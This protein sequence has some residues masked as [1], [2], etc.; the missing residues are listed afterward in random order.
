[1]GI[2]VR[3]TLIRLHYRNDTGNICARDYPVISNHE[4][5]GANQVQ[6]NKY[7]F[8]SRQQNANQTH[9]IV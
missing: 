3:K 7:T 5:K 8:V 4:T 2:S 6:F 9:N 1:M